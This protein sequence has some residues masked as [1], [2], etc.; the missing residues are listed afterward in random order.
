VDAKQLQDVDTLSEFSVGS[1]LEGAWLL[2][3]SNV[4]CPC[5]PVE[6]EQETNK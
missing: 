5:L 4:S 6:C 1:S 3:D 2:G